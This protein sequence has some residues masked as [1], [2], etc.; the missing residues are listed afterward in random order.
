MRPL[1]SA[2]TGFTVCL[3]VL[4]ALPVVFPGAPNFLAPVEEPLQGAMEAMLPSFVQS[5]PG[6]V[7]QGVLPGTTPI[8]VGVSLPPQDPGAVDQLIQTLYTPGSP[9]YHHFL[10][11]SE[12]RALFSPTPA[13]VSAVQQYYASYGLQATPS[14]DHLMFSISGPSTSVGAAFHTHFDRYRL[15]DGSEAYGPAAS[16]VV[17]RG[18]GI[19]GLTGFTNHM[20]IQPLDTAPPILRAPSPPGVP[21]ACS[22]LPG[23]NTVSQL[24][25]QYN[26]TPVLATDNGAGVTVGIVDAY[27]SGFTQAQAQSDITGFASGCGLPTPKINFL[28]PERTTANLNSSSSSGWGGET[29]LDIEVVDTMAPGATIDL[30]FASDSSLAVYESVDFLVAHNVTQTISMSWGEPDSGTMAAFP[31]PCLAFYSCNASWDGSYEFL[32]PVFAEAVAE[33]ISPF[34]A[35]GDCGAYDGT[36]ILTTDYPASD[37]YVTDIGG[38]AFNT[39]GTTY[40]GEVGSNGNGKNCGG[41][42]GDDGGGGPALWGKPFWQYGPGIPTG[43]TQRMTPD[44]AASSSDGT[45]EAT[46]IWAGLTAVADEAHGGTGLGLLGPSLYSILRSSHY[47]KDFH[48]ILVG[49]NGY[50]AG[51]AW[52]QD[53]GMGSPNI[54]NLIPD[55]FRNQSQPPQPGA[56]TASL[57]VSPGN[58]AMERFTTTV[59]GGTPPYRYDYVPTLYAG[60]WSTQSVLNYTY[61][62][63][64]TFFPVVEVWDAHGNWTQSF[65]QQVEIGGTVLAPTLAVS[66]TTVTLGSPVTY[67]TT[68]SGGTSPYLYTYQWGD[69]SYGYN[70]TATGIHTY[71]ATGTYCATVEV[72]DSAATTDGGWAKAPCVTVTRGTP[73]ALSASFVPSSSSGT[74]WLHVNFTS[75]VS[76]GTGPYTYT[77]TFGDG[78]T[79]SVLASPSH[80]Y[81]RTGTFQVNLTV[82]DSAAATVGATPWNITVTS[83]PLTASLVATPATGQKPLTVSFTSAHTGGTPAYT[84]LWSFGDGSLGSQAQDPSHIYNVSGTY[85]VVLRISDSLS[86]LAYAY[87]NITV[88]NYPLLVATATASVGTGPVPLAVTFTG[89]ATGG[90][91]TY[92]WAWTFGDG[93]T[94]TLQS[95]THTYL[96]TGTFP[97]VVAVTDQQPVKAYAYLNVTVTPAP[98]LVNASALPQAGTAPLAVTFNGTGYGGVAPYTWSWNF[99]DGSAPSLLQNP[100]HVYATTGTYSATLTVTDSK[101]TVATGTSLTITVNPYTVTASPTG[102]TALTVGAPGH[103]AVNGS[104]GVAPYTFAWTFGDGATSS[105]QYPSHSYAS[106]GTFPV[107]AVAT[108]SAGVSS[109]SATLSVKVTS[110]APLVVTMGGTGS[111]HV[112]SPASLWAK[113]TGGT[114]SYSYFWSFGDGQTL[115]TASVNTTTHTYASACTCEVTVTVT[116]SAGSIATSAPPFPVDVTAAVMVQQQG[117]Q[118]LSLVLLAII[119][120]AVVA[121]VV[122]ALLL[123]RRSK[124]S[125]P[126]AAMTPYPGYGA[127]PTAVNWGAPPA[128][129]PYGPG[130]GPPA[131]PPT[132]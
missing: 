120:V 48:D 49:N 25:G 92:T 98:L 131:P 74:A 21:A 54:A 63:T 99:G 11:P 15:A 46:P 91:G 17:P 8:T 16:V 52:D 126:P 107:T 24:E 109:T 108:D 95:P 33:G 94:S 62:G 57:T 13:Q 30:T 115:S 81:T 102:P 125:P 61:T 121:A 44:V 130:G 70:E 55:L 28:Y 89:G 59:V 77:W 87:T 111:V 127:P 84:Y 75:T 105:L 41:N 5:F 60:Q 34:A 90:F 23:G 83:P 117:S 53:S 58:T 73:G 106:V 35:S 71:Y 93:G 64:G 129:G 7:D 29:Q 22:S 3:V 86:N 37:A 1:R 40:G 100:S 132:G 45:S 78:S 116:D 2:L 31:P 68:V 76:G 43:S 110:V 124:G 112:G 51:R 50:A 119:A 118:G 67:S 123:R 36:G 39:S 14:A 97:V 122:A 103:F 6:S 26:E 96:R 47:T 65:P 42:A 128:S 19:S 10:T 72:V 113:A 18:L 9:S 4:A 82:S 80:V 104:G 12:Y 88:L 56:F 32:H 38:T 79:P 85:P 20:G 69:G 27:D 101:G 66:S 114:G